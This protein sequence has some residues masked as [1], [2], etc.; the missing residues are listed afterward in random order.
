MFYD[1]H[2]FNSFYKIEQV[3]LSDLKKMIE[4]LR[5]LLFWLE[6]NWVVLKT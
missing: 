1:L 5:I 2:A 6:L 3:Y 4:E